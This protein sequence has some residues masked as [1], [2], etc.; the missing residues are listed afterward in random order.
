MPSGDTNIRKISYI[1]QMLGKNRKGSHS[2]YESLIHRN[3]C[4][5][6]ETMLATPPI[7]EDDYLCE[8]TAS[9]KQV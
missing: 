6:I 5:T 1:L 9:Q 3:V 8:T 7:A 4:D 2:S